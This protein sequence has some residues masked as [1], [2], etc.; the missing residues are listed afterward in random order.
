MLLALIVYDFKY[1]TV[2]CHVFTLQGLIVY[3]FAYS[4]IDYHFLTL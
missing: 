2:A 1:S 4:G 3:D